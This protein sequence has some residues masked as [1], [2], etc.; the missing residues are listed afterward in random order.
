MISQ[1]AIEQ[2]GRDAL[3]PEAHRDGKRAS[4]SPSPRLLNRVAAVL[5]WPG[6]VFF[7][8]L[9]SWAR[10]KVAS[11]SADAP[12]QVLE[13]GIGSGA[14][15]TSYPPRVHLTAVDADG[16][17]L[18]RARSRVA[19][20]ALDNVLG[21]HR[22]TTEALRFPDNSFDHVSAFRAVFEHM[23]PLRRRRSLRE[24]IR[25]TRMGGSLVLIERGNRVRLQVHGATG[26][27]AAIKRD[28]TPSWIRSCGLRLLGREQLDPVGF[29]VALRFQKA[30]PAPA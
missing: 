7:S 26:A 19:A 24:L 1:P 28:E 6:R 16:S 23:S 20:R 14:S 18:V 9:G 13:V 5:T 11:F 2:S 27:G 29:F 12:A 21:L 22:M 3:L 15:L 8:A 30:E 17:A 4:R 25:V 10:R